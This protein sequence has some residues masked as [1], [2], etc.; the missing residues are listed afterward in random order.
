VFL[1]LLL[2]F[3]AMPS[4]GRAQDQKIELRIWDQFT[5]PGESANADAIYKAYSD[6]HPNVTIKRE[7]FATDQ[8]RQTVN[9]AL[10]S[11]TGPDIIF[12]DAGPGYAGVLANAGLLTPLMRTRRSTAGVTR[13]PRSR[14][15]QP[16]STARCT[17]CRSRST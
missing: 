11:G 6:A 7:S 17:V 3:G 14:S 9:T 12:Y 10:A 1:T 8:M 4:V 2:A 15:R 16:R 5:D 13:S